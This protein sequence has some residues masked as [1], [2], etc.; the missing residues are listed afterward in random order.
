[1]A[2]SAEELFAAA[3]ELTN[4]ADRAAVVDRE[5]VGN[6][7]LRTEVESLLVADEQASQFLEQSPAAG[8]GQTLGA[9]TG[10]VDVIE[11]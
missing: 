7:E 11:A 6:P 9:T 1:M 2:K 8:P 4:R 10:M 3:L 5:C